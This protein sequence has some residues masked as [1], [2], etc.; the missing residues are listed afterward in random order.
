MGTYEVMPSF[1]FHS[2]SSSLLLEVNR[3][4]SRGGHFESQEN[5]KPCLFLHF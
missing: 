4:L 1:F 2:F 3:P 5:K